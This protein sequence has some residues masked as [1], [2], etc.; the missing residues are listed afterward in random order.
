[1]I[2][3]PFKIALIV[4]LNMIF[5]SCVSMKENYLFNEPS[6]NPAVDTTFYVSG[7]IYDDILTNEG[8][9]TKRSECI[10]VETSKEAAYSGDLG[11]IIKWDRQVA[12]C[13]WLGLGFGWDGWTAKDLSAIEQSKL[14]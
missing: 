4:V 1:M 8:W 9:Y 14:R 3:H 11:L 7:E 5:Y 2:K 13:P 10:T 6:S 12:G